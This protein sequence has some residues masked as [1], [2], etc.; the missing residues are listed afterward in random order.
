MCFEF[1]V[2]EVR[3][4]LVET[5]FR[6]ESLINCDT[7]I[8]YLGMK[9]A[10]RAFQHGIIIGSKAMPQIGQFPYLSCSISGCIG[11]V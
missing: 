8:A 3:R 10:H 5:S 11:Q 2:D 1:R 4:L 7:A 9:G 6:G